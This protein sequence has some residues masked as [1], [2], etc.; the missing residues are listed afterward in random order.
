LIVPTPEEVDWDAISRDRRL[1]SLQRRKS[2]F[3]LG[4]LVTK[5]AAH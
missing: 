1:Q 3:L 4:L 2:L 5:S